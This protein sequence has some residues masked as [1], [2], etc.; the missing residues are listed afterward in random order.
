MGEPKNAV[1]A[2]RWLYVLAGKQLLEHVQGTHLVTAAQQPK[3]AANPRQCWILA[4]WACCQ[5]RFSGSLAW[6]LVCIALAD[7]LYRGGTLHI[8]LNLETAVDRLLS[9]PRPHEH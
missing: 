6:V 7:G 8:T 1:D 9:S 4:V 5:L 3:L 2:A